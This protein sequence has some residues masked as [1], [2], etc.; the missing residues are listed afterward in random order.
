MP[1]LIQTVTVPTL[2]S[3]TLFGARA[4]AWPAVGPL[5]L[6]LEPLAG[7]PPRPDLR[8]LTLVLGGICAS[9]LH[10]LTGESPRI[11][12]PLSSFPSVPGHE[13][14]ARTAEGQ[15]VVVDPFIGCAVRGLEPCPECSRGQTA[16][17]RRAAEAGGGIARGMML[18]F[19]RDLP[20]GWSDTLWAHPSQ[21]HAVPDSLP[22]AAALLT[23]PLAVAMHAL[24]QV[25]WNGSERVLVVGAGTIGLCVVAAMRM[26]DL[27]APLVAARHRHQAQA[28]AALGGHPVVAAGERWPRLGGAT[29][30]EG[31][32][33]RPL[34]LGGFDVVVDAVS[35]PATLGRAAAAVRAGGTLVRAGDVGTLPT[36][37]R[38]AAWIPD[39]RLLG[40]FG[41]GLERLLDGRSVHTFDLVL[42]RS[43]ALA[44]PLTALVTHT[45]PLAAYREALAAAGGRRQQG[46]IKVAFRGPDRSS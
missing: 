35:S 19:C 24:L 33:G 11:L 4:I 13:I 9:D 38:D 6:A 40:P 7:P 12:W 18:G 2:L 8:P 34:W 3:R 42:E 46:S 26:L 36:R 16:L 44:Q 27:P 10:A 29:P 17:C 20:G 5:H 22:D 25:P 15:R 30:V 28:A 41:Y 21:L 39:V 37:A 23:E 45:F 1:R 43:P 32:L 31:W 14:L